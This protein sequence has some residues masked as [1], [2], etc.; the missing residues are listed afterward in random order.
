MT[1]NVQRRLADVLDNYTTAKEFLDQ[2]D[3]VEEPVVVRY[4]S[5]LASLWSRRRMTIWADDGF[6]SRTAP[7]RGRPHFG[8]IVTPW[9]RLLL[10]WRLRRTLNH[11]KAWGNT[12][13]LAV[14]EPH[15]SSPIAKVDDIVRRN[16]ELLP[17]RFT[18]ER[19]LAF[20]GVT[21]IVA[22]VPYVDEILSFL[23][24]PLPM[25]DPK[26]GSFT[27]TPPSWV[28]IVYSALFHLALFVAILWAVVT[29]AYRPYRSLLVGGGVIDA[30]AWHGAPYLIHYGG[31]PLRS[32]PNLYVAE[33]QLYAAIGR[34]K[35]L[36]SAFDVF[37][38]LDAVALLIAV[39]M[40]VHR[41]G[42]YYSDDPARRG[43]VLG[44]TILGLYIIFLLVIWRQTR[45]RRIRAGLT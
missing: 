12:Q 32:N 31:F 13:M 37:A 33:W 41:G 2:L 43:M 5:F 23:E 7:R 15:T 24:L 26:T 38:R 17:K 45:E 27:D 39:S 44:L 6:P 25:F 42:V 1:S 8:F 3:R 36:D 14:Y 28:V 40:L 22:V 21:S 4:P 18:L 16:L 9:I 10:D 19:I 11:V 30:P 29:V 35:P 34:R 20:I